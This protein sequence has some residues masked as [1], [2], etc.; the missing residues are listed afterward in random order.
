LSLGPENDDVVRDILVSA[1]S[2]LSVGRDDGIHVR[3]S[4]TGCFV[5]TW[6]RRKFTVIVGCLIDSRYVVEIEKRFGVEELIKEDIGVAGALALEAITIS[7]D[8]RPKRRRQTGPT[9][10]KPTFRS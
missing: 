2:Q 9:Y 4:D 1:S 7:D 3:R 6:S 10:A 8:R 5:I